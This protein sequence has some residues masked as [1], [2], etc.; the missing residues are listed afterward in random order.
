MHW[1]MVCDT[2]H[3]TATDAVAAMRE[4]LA[5]GHVSFHAFPFNVQVCASA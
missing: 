4:A 2:H 3:R 1:C 5:V